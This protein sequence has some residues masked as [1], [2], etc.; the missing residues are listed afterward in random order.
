[1]LLKMI[2]I[3]FHPFSR[4]RFLMLQP[5]PGSLRRR[6]SIHL[7]GAVDCQEKGFVSLQTKLVKGELPTCPACLEFLKVQNFDMETL[8]ARLNPEQVGHPEKDAPN[9][10]ALADEDDAD[11]LSYAK[12][13]YPVIVLL[14]PG[15]FGKKLP[16][17]CTLCK[18]ARWPGGKVGDLC[19]R[20]SE[21]VRGF[22]DSH[23]NSQ[24][25]IS[26]SQ[27]KRHLGNSQQ[28]DCCGLEVNDTTRSGPLGNVWKSEFETWI[29]MTN[30]EQFGRHIYW[31]EKSKDGQSWFIR[32]QT[33][34]KKVLWDI[35]ESEKPICEECMKLGSS[36]CVVRA[37]SKHSQKYMAARLLHARLFE[38]KD[39]VKEVEKAFYNGGLYAI[40]PKKVNETLALKTDHLQQIVRANWAHGLWAL[41]GPQMDF[42]KSTV[43]PSLRYSTGSVPE[44]FSDVLVRFRAYVASGIASESDQVNLKLAAAALDGTLDGHPLLQGLSLQ[45]LR[46]LDKEEWGVSIRGRRNR[47]CSREAALIADA[48][49][50]LALAG[51]NWKLGQMP[52]GSR[53]YAHS[54][55][56][57]PWKKNEK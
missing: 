43:Q 3:H 7:K 30:L 29:A 51:G 13:M 4:D 53:T 15:S 35:D 54:F 31:Q 12:K 57:C 20:K 19:A 50:K 36:T 22:L 45:C 56:R 18:T 27:G 41:K 40:D 28:T 42:F 48:G 44:C 1:M 8:Q 47:E 5:G 34:K 6:S 11:P 32:S 25:H 17:R 9:A 37:V 2:L 26:L 14:P 46:L 10:G 52:F 23:L 16:Y 33:C 38:G 24:M 21:S 39:G 55:S 49:L